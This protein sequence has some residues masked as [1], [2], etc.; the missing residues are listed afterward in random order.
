MSIRLRTINGTRVALCGY[1]TDAAPGDT[2]LD[3]A[4]HYALAAKFSRD[5]KT[6]TEYPG[7]WALMDSQKIRDADT[8]EDLQ[9]HDDR[10][11]VERGAGHE[12]AVLSLAWD[13]QITPKKHYLIR[14]HGPE[15]IEFQNDSNSHT[16]YLED[17]FAA[18]HGLRILR[19]DSDGF[20]PHDGGEC[21]VPEDSRVDVEFKDGA[22]WDNRRAGALA[23][24][25][26]VKYRPLE[27]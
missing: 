21:P 4:D 5:Y 13:G 15:S 9:A 12:Y 6:G 2:Y 14:R 25:N 17:D 10:G 24:F 20:I 8:R 7:E 1:E 22:E 11:K 19:A 16:V 3:D 27:D 18:A 23:W 26:V